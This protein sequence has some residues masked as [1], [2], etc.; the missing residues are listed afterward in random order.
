M[1]LQC[2]RE[3]ELCDR[4]EHSIREHVTV[5]GCVALF[6][7]DGGGM[8]DISLIMTKRILELWLKRFVIRI[9]SQK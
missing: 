6:I 3:K 7:V 2:G 8:K 1:I 5:V 4:F 9:R